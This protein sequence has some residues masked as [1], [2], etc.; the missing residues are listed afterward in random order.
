MDEPPATDTEDNSEYGRI[1]PLGWDAIGDQEPDAEEAERL[2]QINDAEQR[3]G[4]NED[5]GASERSEG[6]GTAGDAPS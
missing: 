1:G 6:R 2:R 3:A 4:G 5:A